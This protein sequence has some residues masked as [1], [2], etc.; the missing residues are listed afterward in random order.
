MKV[1]KA[2]RF[3]PAC[4]PCPYID[5]CVTVIKSEKYRARGGEGEGSGGGV[6]GGRGVALAGGRVP[7]A[8]AAAA[9]H[10]GRRGPRHSRCNA[11]V[12]Y[13]Q[14]RLSED[15]AKRLQR[16]RWPTWR[17]SRPWTA[18]GLVPGACHLG[19]PLCL[20]CRLLLQAP[21]E[22]VAGSS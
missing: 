2:G 17:S 15:G 7:G 18:G 1:D 4:Q 20:A 21:A 14:H 9:V 6:V 13:I 5:H 11:L 3:P 19:K 12:V 8:E 22:Q 10:T 16:C